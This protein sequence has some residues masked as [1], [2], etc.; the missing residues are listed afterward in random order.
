MNFV[1]NGDLYKSSCTK[2]KRVRQCTLCSSQSANNTAIKKTGKWRMQVKEHTNQVNRHSS[3]PL[4]QFLSASDLPF[5]P[6]LHER[7]IGSCHATTR[8]IDKARTQGNHHRRTPW[9]FCY[10]K[11]FVRM[12][13]PF[14]NF[15]HCSTDFTFRSWRQWPLSFRK[16]TRL[17]HQFDC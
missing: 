5:M 14:G 12:K 13:R 6:H 10:G 15:L 17:L 8:S 11:K 9:S 16:I 3:G 1:I 4:F 7:N 2:Q